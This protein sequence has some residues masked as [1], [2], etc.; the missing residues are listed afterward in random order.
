MNKAGL[1]D[2]TD[3]GL[4]ALVSLGTSGVTTFLAMPVIAAALVNQLGASEREVGLFSTIQLITL[5][6]GCLAST[7]L[8]QGRCRQYGIAALL[9]MIACDALCLFQPGWS[10]FL[11]LRGLSGAAG[12][13]AV[14]QAT[15]ALGR[16]RN[17]ERSFGLFLAL[18]TLVAV[19]C[20][21]GMPQIIARFGF[22]AGYGLLLAFS[23][24][25][26]V[27]VQSRLARSGATVGMTV[28]G[29][30]TVSDW[31]RCAGVLA[32]ILCFFVGVGVLWTFLALLGQGIGLDAAG[33]ALVL[34][35]SKVVAFLASFL[36]G[37]I[38]NRF[39]RLGPILLSVAVLAGATQ[40]YGLSSGFAGFAAAT[41]LFS[42]G[43]Y[44]IYPF[45]LGAL[46]QVDHDG[47]PMLAAAA[48]TGAGLGI[49]PALIVLGPGGARGIYLVA[50]LAF[51][52]AGLFATLA[53]LPAR[54]QLT[55]IAEGS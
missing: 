32:S 25:A 29:G 15:A 35:M 3:S 11:A 34:S 14:S 54:R 2:R 53:L 42:L 16:T 20:V 39:G 49:G 26:L 9:T 23:T 31:L 1:T 55:A 50:M 51:V 5:S 44:V 28:G 4:A 27:L 47:R 10:A 37:L 30:N 36:P 41:A 22:Y 7:F 38:G 21:Y 8:P 40:A 12:G 6:V 48:L 46:G 43:W 18:Q 45:Q 17:P 19:V 13:V 33:I 52:A 24:L